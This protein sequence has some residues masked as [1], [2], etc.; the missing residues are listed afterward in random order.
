MT[1]TID[2]QEQRNMILEK[3]CEIARKAREQAV[4]DA[5]LVSRDF[6]ET[7]ILQ[8]KNPRIERYDGDR[9]TDLNDY[10]YYVNNQLIIE[11]WNVLDSIAI[12]ENF[13][14]KR[15]RILSGI[16]FPNIREKKANTRT[17]NPA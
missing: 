14:S 2:F 6:G 17:E 12:D 16:G 3:M 8:G 7:V 5:N 13:F 4:I 10:H 9:I 11:G 1:N 15:K